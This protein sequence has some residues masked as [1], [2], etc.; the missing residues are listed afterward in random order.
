VRPSARPLSDRAPL[1]SST[2]PI[3]SRRRS[4]MRPGRQGVHFGD[5]GRESCEPSV[6]GKRVHGGLRTSE[7]ARVRPE[8]PVYGR[9]PAGGAGHDRDACPPAAG[10]A[11]TT[12]PPPDHPSL[13]TIPAA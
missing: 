11:P 9:S 12:C 13:F 1:A 4:V 7:E 6:G 5:L 3:S 10:S 2:R 8:S